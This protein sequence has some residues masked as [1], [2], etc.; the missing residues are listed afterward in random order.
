MLSRSLALIRK[1]V[2]LHLADWV[3]VLLMVLMPLGFM[4]FMVPMS[5]VMLAA[6]GY[7]GASGAETVLP[8]M[9]VMF[10]FFLL[11]LVGDQF[12][13]E[14]GWGTWNRARVAADTSE[15]MLGKMVPALVVLAGQLGLVFGAGVLLFGVR[16]EGS[17]LGL[18]AILAAFTAC[19]AAML[20]ALV[21]Y[22]KTF[23]QFN[24]LNNLFVMVFAGLGGSLAPVALMPEWVQQ[25]ARFTPSFWVIEGLRGVILQGDGLG[26]ALHAA[27]ITLVFAAAFAAIAALRF[28]A[29]EAKVA[30]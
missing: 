10:S 16:V 12:F 13:R 28:K 2:R 26:T 21:A 29:A 15:I 1:D 30:L 8:G 5:K 19:L 22:C 14:H 9:M 3:P 7:S 6:Q 4:A 23:V 18:A 11:G 20:V 24:V 25:A 27:G 17:M